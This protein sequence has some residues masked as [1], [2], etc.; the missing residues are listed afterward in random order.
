MITTTA[1]ETFPLK[2]RDRAATN[3][4]HPTKNVLARTARKYGDRIRSLQVCWKSQVGL[5][6]N[7]FVA[8]IPDWEGAVGA[9][10]G[11]LHP[12]D[13]KPESGYSRPHTRPRVQ[14]F[15][16]LR[17]A[18]IPPCRR[19]FSGERTR[20]ACWHRRLADVYLI[21]PR[22]VRRALHGSCSIFLRLDLRL[23][24]LPPLLRRVHAWRVD[25]KNSTWGAKNFGIIRQLIL[26]CINGKAFEIFISFRSHYMNVAD[27]H[28]IIANRKSSNRAISWDL[29]CITDCSVKSNHF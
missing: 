10:I 8:I 29:I 13:K 17:Q 24:K 23:Q 3:D 22:P 21:P 5:M 4:M 27:C 28:W 16:V 15:T 26:H 19:I 2:K 9:Q 14:V 12:I 18:K 20:L 11:H 6:P 7:P 1:A 25:V